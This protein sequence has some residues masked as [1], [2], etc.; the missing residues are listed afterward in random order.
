M[1]DFL[2]VNKREMEERGWDRVDFVYVTGDAYVDHPSFGSA[3]ISRL[4][5]SRGYRVG[6]I[7]QPDWKQKESVQVFGEPRLG[8][9]VSAG[10]MDSMVNHYTVSGKHRQKDAYSPGGEMGHRPDRSATVYSNLIRQS[11]KKTPIILGGIE[12]SLRRLAHYDYWDNRVRRSVLMDSGADL[13]SYGM[14]EHSILEI[15]EALES[16]IPV[17]EITYIPGTVFKCRDLSRVYE[18]ILLPSFEEI[19]ENKKLYAESFAVQ[20][21]NTDPFTAKPMAESYGTKGYIVQN[22]PAHPLSR[23]EMDDVYA[24]PY[25]RKS[26]PMYE[27]KGGIPALEEIKFSLTSNRGCFGSCSFCALTFHQG[28]ILQ[29]RSHESLIEEAKLMTQEK[30]FKGYIHD[31]GGPT[32]DFRQPSCKKQLTKGVCMN[33]QCLFPTPCKNL[34]VDHRDYVALLRKLRRIPKVKK[35]FIRSGVRFDYVVA[36]KDKTFLRELVEHHVSG[37]LRVAPEHVSDQVLKY[38]GKPSHSVYQQFLREY[39]EANKKT[40]KQ[41]FAVPYFMSS[42]PGCTMKEAVRLAEYVRDLGFTPEQVQDFYP[43][44]STLSTCMYYTGIHPLTGEK[45][46]VPRNPREKAIQRALMQY[47]NPANR[48]LVLEGLK[49]AG[50]MDL[51]GYD[52]KCLIRPIREKASGTGGK[53][54]IQQEKRGNKKKKT[55]R[56][57][58]KRKEKGVR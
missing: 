58:H 14:G 39:E 55:I 31:V 6:M 18:P 35:V 1:Q 49:L 23:E 25:T 15:A 41:Q 44:P 56:N 9:L 26:H 29:T 22:P 38:M 51:V 20:Y 19:S 17:E 50:R 54:G 36:D 8:F 12:A 10:N 46:Y 43:T 33:R 3:I 52:K 24:F 13:I 16:G 7:C 28:R 40:G 48:E 37:Q 32:A 57:V 45:V 42:H 21:K 34:D 4:L 5:E 27:E 47:K 11:Y 53:A 2:P 30:D